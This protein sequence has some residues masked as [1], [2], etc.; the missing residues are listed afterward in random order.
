M[1][2]CMTILL[3][4]DMFY[5][6]WKYILLLWEQGKILNGY[7]KLPIR[8]QPI[9]KSAFNYLVGL[10]EI[11][12]VKFAHG[13]KMFEILLWDWP[14]TGSNS[15][16]LITT[17]SNYNVKKRRVI[18]NEIMVFHNQLQPTEQNPHPCIEMLE[19]V[20]LQHKYNKVLFALLERTLTNDFFKGKIFMN[21]S[22]DPPFDE[23]K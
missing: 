16:L 23:F 22:K 4:L 12:M 1:K 14:V 21:P 10:K 8:P 13:L 20:K 9:K 15:H 2:E 7:N 19:K 5:N 6:E 18:R 11:H 3:F 17:K